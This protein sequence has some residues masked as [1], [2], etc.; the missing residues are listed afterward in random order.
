MALL[1]VR[2]EYLVVSSG[3]KF[4]AVKTEE[5][6]EP[7]VYDCTKAENKPEESG[8]K[9]DE[10]G[11]EEKGSDRI[12]A[13]AFSAS[14]EY[15]ALTDDSKR[16]VL[17]RT[18]PVW[19]CLSTRWVV[20]RCTSLTMTKAE[21]QILVADKSGDVYSFSLLEPQK[22]AELKLGHLSML[23]AVAISPDDRYII[24]ADRDEKIRVSFLKSPY[25][26]QSFCLGHKEFVSSLFV[27]PYQPYWLLSGSGD[28]TLRLWEFE[29]G[30]E[31]Q[32]YD[33]R[34]L[35]GTKSPQKD[36]KFAVSRIASSP[37]GDYIAV[38]CDSF[39][40]VHIF[41]VDFNAQRLMHQE[42]LDLAHSSWDVAFDQLGR[43]W[44]L[45]QSKDC[46]VALYRLTGDCWK[47]DTEDPEVK[48]VTKILHSQWDMFQGAV[49]SICSPR[50]FRY[51]RLSS[52]WENWPWCKVSK[53]SNPAICMFVSVCAL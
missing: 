1:E 20:R 36:K 28:G 29:F 43:L 11:A 3:S 50:T 18:K 47:C 26:I 22:P 30:K 33:L 8:N 45:Q 15:F 27:L 21:D 6:R 38:L 46:P 16:L 2:K 39:P 4:I 14:G 41:R 23:L 42:Q 37:Q 7:F 19:E 17:F 49:V 10:V 5:I 34:E 44:V 25:N 48:K 13:M 52:F 51:C 35:N 9:G 32:S 31:L 40:T 24:T 12:L 53:G